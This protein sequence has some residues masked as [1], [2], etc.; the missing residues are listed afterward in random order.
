MLLGRCNAHP[1]GGIQPSDVWLSG[2][3]LVRDSRQNCTPRAVIICTMECPPRHQFP[4]PTCLSGCRCRG[5]CRLEAIQPDQQQQQ[6][7]CGRQADRHLIQQQEAAG[8]GRHQCTRARRVGGPHRLR[9]PWNL[10]PKPGGEQVPGAAQ[11]GL[12]PVPGAPRGGILPT[13][14]TPSSSS[15]CPNT[16]DC[17]EQQHAC[18]PPKK[19]V[20]VLPACLSKFPERVKMLAVACFGLSGWVC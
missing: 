1:G 18:S 7:G 8:D 9:Q 13:N 2:Q 16:V 3:Q 15:S 19:C 4:T 12:P 6:E 5:H 20:S 14:Q 10:H 11:A 17:T